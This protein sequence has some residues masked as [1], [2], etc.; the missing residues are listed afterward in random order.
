MID[1]VQILQKCDIYDVPG[2][3]EKWGYIVAPDPGERR[4]RLWWAG[5]T[6]G[7]KTVYAWEATVDKVVR[8]AAIKAVKELE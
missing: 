3:M 7:G 4:G 1:K 5:F 8:Q 6:K 2:L